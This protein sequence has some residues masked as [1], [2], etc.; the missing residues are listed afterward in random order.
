MENIYT[1]NDYWEYNPDFHERDTRFKIGNALHL[2]DTI[3]INSIVDIGCG[4]G[5]ILQDICS[6][7]NA[8]GFGYDVSPLAIE[9]SNFLNKN[10]DV[11]YYLFEKN[12]HIKKSDLILCFDVFEHVED[13]LGFLTKINN[14]SKYYL[15]NIPIDIYMT[16]IL[17]GKIDKAREK[18]GHLHYF[19]EN[20][21]ISALNNCGYKIKSKRICESFK[22]NIFHGLTFNQLVLIFPRLF[23]SF[24]SK[25]LC[26]KIFGGSNLMVLAESIKAN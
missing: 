16:G 4:S 3:Q 10:K 2:L 6:I 21:A 12:T 23:F 15:F 17:S 18:V 5:Q 13:Y 20:S 25:S 7:Y 11:E 24:F 26:L 9:R 1:S 14:L 19:T 22:Y 8:K